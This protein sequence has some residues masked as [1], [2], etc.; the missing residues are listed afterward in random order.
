ML[1]TTV[2][3]CETGHNNL[4][5]TTVGQKIAWEYL[6]AY[7]RNS[8]F[9]LNS[10]KQPILSILSIFLLLI[11]LKKQILQQTTVIMCETGYNNLTFTTVEQKIGWEYLEAYLKYS[12]FA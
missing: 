11:N 9:A 6:E 5:F 3:M 2:N 1:Q 8:D 4:T 10:L 12:D 7:L